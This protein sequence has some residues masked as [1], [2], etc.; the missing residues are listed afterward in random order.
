[1]I[2]LL[3]E[4]LI[5]QVTLSFYYV[6]QVWNEAFAKRIDILI[7]DESCHFSTYGNRKI[8]EGCQKGNWVDESIDVEESLSE[9]SMV[10]SI[11]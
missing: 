11:I 6:N 5:L 10:L 1:V 7:F 2:G 8:I 3:D 4:V 9:L